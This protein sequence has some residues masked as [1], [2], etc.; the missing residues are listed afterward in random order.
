MKARSAGLITHQGQG[1]TTLAWCWKVTRKDAQVFGFTSVDAD[2]LID[3]ITYAAATGFT[4]SAIEGRADLSVANLDVAG[5]LDSASLTEADLLA[6]V[7]DGAQVEIFEVNYSDLTQGGMILRTGTIGNV[8]AGRT[9]FSAELRGLAQALQQG[10]GEVF[11]AGCPAN[12][13]DARCKV[14]M[15]PLTV[16]GAVTLATSAREFSDSSRAEADDYFGAGVVTWTSG[17]N[18][19]LPMEIRSFSAGVFQLALPMPY[20]IAV[21]DTYSLVPGCRKRAIDDCKTKF[22]NIVNFRGHPYVPGNDRVIG[23]AAL[24]NV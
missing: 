2:L 12:L 1:T 23:N 5:L 9:G 4:P 11:T 13:G 22:N 6:G 10:V 15:G 8:S 20:A 14:S 7:W 16:T 18:N 3:G 24:E 17:A 19:G 21:G